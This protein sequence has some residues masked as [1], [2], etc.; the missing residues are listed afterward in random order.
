[1]KIDNA[2]ALFEVTNACNLHCKHCYKMPLGGNDLTLGQIKYILE[3]ISDFGIKRLLLTGG[4]PFLRNDLFE[5]IDYAVECNIEDIEINTNGTLLDDA[6]IINEIKERLDTI[7]GL[8][9]SI[10]GAR[11]ETHDFIRGKGQFT[12]LLVKRDSGLVCAK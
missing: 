12:K 8:P 2:G 5:I 9:V 3:K 10:D 7:I 11:S 6:T 1:M 4:E